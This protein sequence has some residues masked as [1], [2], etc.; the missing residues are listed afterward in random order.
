MQ[1]ALEFIRSLPTDLLSD[2]Y[3]EDHASGEDEESDESDGVN[4]FPSDE[5]IST[6]DDQQQQEAVILSHDQQDDEAV[7][8]T[9][10]WI[11]QGLPA[12][13]SP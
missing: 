6:D 5:D 1:T 13:I 8:S 2:Y 11:F 10:S 7:K 4:D 12:C 9:R 3:P